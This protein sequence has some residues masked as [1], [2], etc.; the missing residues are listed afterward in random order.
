MACSTTTCWRSR[1]CSSRPASRCW[2]STCTTPRSRRSGRSQTLMG[3]HPEAMIVTGV[4]Q[5][6]RSRQL[7]R[8]AGV[9]VV[10]TMDVTDEPIDLNIGLDHGEAGAAAVRYLHELGHTQDR[11]PHGARRSAGAAAACRI[12]EADARRS[13]CRRRGWCRAC[14]GSRTPRWAANCS[15]RCWRTCRMSRR[16]SPATTTWRWERCSSAS[17]AGCA[18]PRTSRSSGSTTSISAFRRCRR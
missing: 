16:C 13:G 5:T 3:Y 9:P 1:T 11:A 7:L 18:C 8:N 4:D 10:Q 15:P 17:G 6:E 12:P 2:C 14:R